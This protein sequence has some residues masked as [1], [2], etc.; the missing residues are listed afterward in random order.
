MTPEDLLFLG[1]EYDLT[2][3]S[4]NRLSLPAVLR[5]TI[6]E[7]FGEILVLLI[8]VN[9]K[10]WIYPEKY[11]RK[12]MAKLI[13]Q[14][15]PAEAILRFAHSNISMTFPVT[16]DKQGRFVLPDKIIR[17]S[18]LKDEQGEKPGAV[19]I[20]VTGVR[21]HLEVWKR[22]DWEIYCNEINSNPED[23]KLRAKMLM[24]QVADVANQ[25]PGEQSKVALSPTA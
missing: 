8:G 10:P 4:N 12:L 24:S 19:D 13:P 9:N 22:M 21:D 7:R 20:T 17:R 18:H 5:S 14:D 2:V 1:G 15:V 6:Q 11:Y 25:T 16:M 23:V 3:D